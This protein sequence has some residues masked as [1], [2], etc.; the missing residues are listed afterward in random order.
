MKEYPTAYAKV[1]VDNEASLR[2]FRTCG[3]RKKFYILTKD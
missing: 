2:L 1:K 3:F